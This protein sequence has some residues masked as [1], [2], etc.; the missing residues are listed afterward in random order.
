MSNLRAA[1]V[2]VG[3]LG[4]FGSDLTWLCRLVFAETLVGLESK[5]QDG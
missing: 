5:A 4:C 1:V 3:Y 2:V